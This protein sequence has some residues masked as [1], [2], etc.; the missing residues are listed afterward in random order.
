MARVPVGE[1]PEHGLVRLSWRNVGERVR[2]CRDYTAAEL[3]SVPQHMRRGQLCQSSLLP[4]RLILR[5]DGRMIVDRVV[6][7]AGARHDRPLFVAEELSLEP[8]SYRIELD[9]APEAELAGKLL[10][11]GDDFSE[12]QA[13]AALEA[14]LHEAQQY[15]LKEPIRVRAGHVV[16]VSLNEDARSLR[17]FGN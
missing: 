7:P 17:I 13:R 15:R 9:Y 8:G 6:R 11:A 5:I 10:E 3:Q 4:Y 1:A 12:E 16:L 2:I 14:A